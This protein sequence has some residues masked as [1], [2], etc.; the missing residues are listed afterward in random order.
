MV[1][2]GWQRVD[3]MSFEHWLFDP[4]LGKIVASVFGILIIR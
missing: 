2:D 3:T 4:T 1:F